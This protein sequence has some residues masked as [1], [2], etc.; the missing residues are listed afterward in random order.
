[1]GGRSCRLEYALTTTSKGEVA[2]RLGLDRLRLPVITAPMFLVSGPELVIS[3]CRAGLLGA[4]PAANARD[5]QGLAQWLQLIAAQRALMPTPAPYAVNINV[6]PGRYADQSGIVGACRDARVPLVITSVGD[7]SAMTKAV[8]EWGGVVFHDV[9]TVRH[10]EKAAEAGVDGLILVCNGAGG[11]SGTASA[12]SF[13]P[14]VRQFFDK[15][16]VLAGG[17]A[18]GRAILAARALGADL[19]YM[20][21]RFIASAE[22]LA[23]PAYKQSVVDSDLKDVLF[24]AAISGLP[25]NFL[26]QSIAS[27][28]LNP[29]HLPRSVGSAT[30]P[31]PEGIKAWKHIWSAGQAV[32][33]IDSVPPVSEIVDSLLQEYRDACSRL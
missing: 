14:R 10:A 1:M 27:A 33:L 5:A 22:S 29:D 15:T 8:H 31:L 3:A 18:T 11:H 4:F 30:T 2:D 28:G 13:L 16:I 32:A 23:S 20:G 12:F 9:T 7:P 19:V 17:I 21:T 6:S 26:R 25:A 24:T